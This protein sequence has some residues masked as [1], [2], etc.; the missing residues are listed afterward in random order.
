MTAENRNLHRDYNSIYKVD[1]AAI[2]ADVAKDARPFDVVRFD[3]Q[4]QN[5]DTALLAAGL[6]EIKPTLSAAGNE[7]VMADMQV[8]DRLFQRLEYTDIA[9]TDA[10]LWAQLSSWCQ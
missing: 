6:Q 5:L 9:S 2:A 8:S 1:R 10:R 4:K 3:I 7:E